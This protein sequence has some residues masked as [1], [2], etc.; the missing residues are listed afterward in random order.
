MYKVVLIFYLKTKIKIW[1]L[2]CGELSKLNAALSGLA[3]KARLSCVRDRSV[4][5]HVPV[6]FTCTTAARMCFALNLI[7]GITSGDILANITPENSLYI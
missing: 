6:T 7:L 1:S 3:W 5:L 4:H 2:E